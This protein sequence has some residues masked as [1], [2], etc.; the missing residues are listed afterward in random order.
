MYILGSDQAL[1]KIAVAVAG[2]IDNQNQDAVHIRIEVA[3]HA[4]RELERRSKIIGYEEATVPNILACPEAVRE[5]EA[6][7]SEE[8]NGLERGFPKLSV[9]KIPQERNM[10]YLS[11]IIDFFLYLFAN[12]TIV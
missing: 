9:L 12:Q 11:R 10:V 1:A 3:E 4:F 7:Y 8:G 6:V 2:G 5:N